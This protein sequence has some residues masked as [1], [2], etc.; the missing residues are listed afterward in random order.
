MGLGAWR[1]L[2]YRQPLKHW[3]CSIAPKGNYVAPFTNME[4]P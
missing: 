1:D 2:R 3:P 4:T